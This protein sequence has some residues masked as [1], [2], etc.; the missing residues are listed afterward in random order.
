MHEG[1]WSLCRSCKIYVLKMHDRCLSPLFSK[2]A[3]TALASILIAIWLLCR[4]CLGAIDQP[5]GSHHCE[6]RK[7]EA[8]FLRFENWTQ[9]LSHFF[10]LNNSR[11]FRWTLSI[12]DVSVCVLFSLSVD[13]IPK[14][15]LKVYID[16]SSVRIAYSSGIERAANSKQRQLQ[17]IWAKQSKLDG[18][19]CECMY[20]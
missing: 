7:C 18:C 19:A 1:G 14:V 2:M 15:S 9:L 3:G 17:R 12:H 13:F 8:H 4:N 16:F 5:I 6:S 20:L 10:A 11:F